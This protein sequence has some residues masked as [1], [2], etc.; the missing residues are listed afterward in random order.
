MSIQKP[1]TIQP[2]TPNRL[3]IPKPKLDRGGN[4]FKLEIRREGGGW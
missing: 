3:T 2:D 1:Y 4:P